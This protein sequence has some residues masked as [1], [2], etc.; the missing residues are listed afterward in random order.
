NPY[1]FEGFTYTEIAYSDV[2]K[3]E[4]TSDLELT[5]TLSKPSVLVPGNLA[6]FAADI[7]SPAALEKAGKDFGQAPVGTGPFKFDHWTKDVELVM[8]AYDDYWGGRP[9]L[10]RVIWQTISDDTVRLTSLQT[11]AID[12]A[13]QIDFKDAATVKNDPNL[14]LLT[15]P[16]LSVQFLAFNEAIPPF[17]NAKLRQAVQHA[18]N[19]KN[20]ADAVFYGQY[21]LGGG[22]IAPTLLGYDPSLADRYPYDVA[23][24]KALVAESGASNVSFTLINRSNSF[25]PTIGQLIQADLAA[26]GITA[27]L[28][29]LEDADFYSQLNA[30]KAQA[31][32][33][34]WTW[35]NAD[36]DNVMFSLFTAP[37]AVS[38]MGYKNDRVN[39]LNTS[40]QSEP[41]PKKREAMYV[42]A[43]K[44]ILDDAIMAVLGYP[45]RA[46]GA[47]AKVQNLPVSPLGSL[48]LRTVDLA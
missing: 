18:I 3:A 7:V 42:E 24:A 46:I 34:D 6:V 21:T 14:Q 27:N 47:A 8:T 13:N 45:S 31:F 29:A 39:Q 15:G 30:S 35:D 19:K 44:L 20:I 25:W 38:R 9:K 12:V 43:Q 17:D 16:F 4:A 36:P 32:I 22:P 48:P 23:K 41:D 28:Q 33:N 10:D 26:I 11:G 5:L 37:R 2:V 1:H 40:A